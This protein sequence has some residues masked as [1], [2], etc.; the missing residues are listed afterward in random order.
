MKIGA[1]DEAVDKV[2]DDMKNLIVSSPE[3][4]VQYAVVMLLAGCCSQLARIADALE[5]D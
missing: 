1:I 4:N 3:R 5:R 2:E